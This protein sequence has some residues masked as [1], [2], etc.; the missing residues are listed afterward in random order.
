MKYNNGILSKL[1]NNSIVISD[2]QYNVSERV[3]NFCKHAGIKQGDTVKFGLDE[4]NTVRY[5]DI[6][7][8]KTQPNSNSREDKTQPNSREVNIEIQSIFKELPNYFDVSNITMS[9]NDKE[10][11]IKQTIFLYDVRKQAE[12]RILQRGD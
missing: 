12:K 4:T 3:L 8:E 10:L 9:D 7:K 6:E 1:N 2:K 5:I 11:L